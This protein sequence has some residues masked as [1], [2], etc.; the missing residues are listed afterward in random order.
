MRS[1][2]GFGFWQ[3]AWKSKAALNAAAFDAAWAAMASFKAD[4]G[5]PLG[6]KPTH[7]LVPPA[8]RAA[9]NEV[10]MVERLASGASNANYKA[11]EVVVVP[12]LA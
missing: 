8:L 3:Q 9:A 2:V 10:V 11:V 12:W 7:L 5:R 6:I 1:N 4:G